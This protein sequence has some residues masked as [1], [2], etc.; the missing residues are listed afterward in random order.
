MEIIILIT[1]VESSA[2]MLW[3]A[4]SYHKRRQSKLRTAVRVQSGPTPNHPQPNASLYKK[5]SQERHD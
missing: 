2:L 5:W 1:V 3:V 4:Y